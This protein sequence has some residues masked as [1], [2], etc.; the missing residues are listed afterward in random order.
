LTLTYH[1]LYNYTSRTLHMC[2]TYVTLTHHVLY[3][4]TDYI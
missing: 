4:Y 2:G 1:V 3:S